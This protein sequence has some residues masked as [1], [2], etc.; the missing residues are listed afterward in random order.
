MLLL[1]TVSNDFRSI[2]R[3]AEKAIAQVSDGDLHWQPDKES[4][5][6]AI[7]MK[8]IS[9]NLVSRWTDFLT[10]DGEKPNRNRDA[11]FEDSNLP[12]EE[13]LKQWEAGW[14]C[15]FKTLA[16]ISESDL[17]KT[18]YIRGEAH[19]VLKAITRQIWHYGYHVG[20]IVY[21]AKHLRSEKWNTLSIPRGKSGD[22][23][24]RG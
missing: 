4:N 10:S 21:I 14:D 15:L 22:Y 1:P 17:E 8:H 16:G 12:R 3:L 11:E 20:Q 18:V 13:L 19:S 9:G 5:S 24:P 6:I 23:V 2:K 7:I